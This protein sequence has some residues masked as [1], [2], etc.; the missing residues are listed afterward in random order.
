MDDF[1]TESSGS[2]KINPY[3]PNNRLITRVEVEN[4]LKRGNIFKK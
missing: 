2:V 4:I 1:T 3:N